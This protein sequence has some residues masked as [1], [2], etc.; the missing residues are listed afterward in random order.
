MGGIP[1][2]SK[3][4]NTCRRR[5][6]RVR[7]LELEA[8]LGAQFKASNPDPGLVRG[9]EAGMHAVPEERARVHGL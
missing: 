4:C 8:G 7:P 3:G 6:F 1:Y 9:D 2:K 5:K